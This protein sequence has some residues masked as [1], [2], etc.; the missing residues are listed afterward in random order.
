LESSKVPKSELI[1]K[2]S[3][4]DSQKTSINKD[5]QKQHYQED[6]KKAENKEV[7][8][9]VR[10]RTTEDLLMHA[11]ARS[12]THEKS[13]SQPVIYKNHSKKLTVFAGILLILLVASL[14]NSYI[15][16]NNI[17]STAG[18]RVSQPN[19]KPSGYRLNK[20]TAETG[21]A[22]LFYKSTSDD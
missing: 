15:N 21:H 5:S 1:K 7:N 22:L 17:S 16:N 8:Y 3:K 12:N 2:F 11:I 18:F 10:P 4:K 6:A 13:Y 20:I 14:G 19:Y 9:S